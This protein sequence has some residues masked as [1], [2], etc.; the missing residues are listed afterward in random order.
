MLAFDAR[1]SARKRRPADVRVT[2]AVVRASRWRH[3]GVIALGALLWAVQLAAAPAYQV[4]AIRVDRPWANPSAPG[5]VMGAA[6]MTITNTGKA[7]DELVGA[8]SPTAAH[9]DLHSTAIVESLITMRN[10]AGVP[11]APGATVRLEPVGLHVMLID[12]HA[13]LQPGTAFPLTLKFRRAG[14]ITVNVRV[15][16][17]AVPFGKQPAAHH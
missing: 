10:I 7:P 16:K 15:E 8:S 11:V 5:M 17:A 12:L 6:Y 3:A 13:P 4:G 1:A 2:H 14:T 9:A